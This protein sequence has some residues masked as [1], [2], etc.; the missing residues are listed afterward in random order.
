MDLIVDDR[1]HYIIPYLNDITVK[2]ITVGDYIFSCN[3]KIIC[4]V[5]RKTI[6][7]LASSIKDGRIKNHE[8]LLDAR[9]EYNCK[10]LYI[11]EGNAYP[12]INRS[13]NRIKYKNLQERLDILMFTDDIK[14]I[15][16]KNC[17]HTANRLSDLRN[18][19]LKMIEHGSVPN[20]HV[21]ELN[22]ILGKK[23]VVTMDTI[24]V[25]MLSCISNIS[26]VSAVSIL[27]KFKIK[28]ILLGKTCSKDWYNLT[29]EYNKYK[30]GNRGIKMWNNCNNIHKH[31]GTQ[32]KILACIN[33]ITCQ[34][35]NT[36]LQNINIFDIINGTFENNIISNIQKN[37]TRKIGNKIEEK[38]IL[39]FNDT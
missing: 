31:T 1:E 22:E 5:E 33:G 27:Q 21:N 12:N 28:Q 32:A 30:F 15:W 13:F 23:R 20:I 8:Q 19:F 4:V 29:S 38:I 39:V 36:I 7:D 3:G 10:I 24:H 37:K 9:K 11:I 26:Y 25:N 35:A 34:T 2:R 6:K 18:T 17:I 16:T 14:I